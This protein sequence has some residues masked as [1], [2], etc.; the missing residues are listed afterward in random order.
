MGL[1]SI[2]SGDDAKKAAADKAAGYASGYSTL[3]DLYGQGRDALSAG[4]DKAATYYQPMYDTATRGYSAL[5]DALGINGTE[6]SGRAVAA[7]R[8]NPGYNVQLDTGLEAID[9]GAASRGLLTSPSLAASEQKYGND[10]ASLGWSKFIDALGN[11]R[12]DLA[13]SAGGL[14]S[15][16]AGAGAGIN[17]SYQGQGA[18]P[19]GRRS[20]RAA[21]RPRVTWPITAPRRI[22]GT[23][24]STAASCWRRSMAAAPV[25]LLRRRVEASKQCLILAFRASTFRRLATYSS[26]SPTRKRRGANRTLRTRATL[27]LQRCQKLRT[28]RRILPRARPRCCTRATYRAP[29]R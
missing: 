7:F 13:T 26:R 22:C 23:R 19:T 5:G 8:A 10:L 2:F 16:A 14:A 28:E 27:H 1:F 21:H 9:R 11:Y 18:R 12:G 3:G 17:A 29:R 24:F 20:A 4:F 25:A 6:G 15:T